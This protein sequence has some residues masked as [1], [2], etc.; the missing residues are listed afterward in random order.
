MEPVPV[1]CGVCVYTRAPVWCL[2]SVDVHVCA[3]P[4]CVLISSGLVT[5][6]FQLDLSQGHLD[7]E[8]FN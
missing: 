3:L 2:Y 5:A 6:V 7:R 8:D 1:V 4:V